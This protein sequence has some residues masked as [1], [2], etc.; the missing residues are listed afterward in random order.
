MLQ[1]FAIFENI[2]F[3]IL[4]SSFMVISWIVFFKL[5]NKSKGFEISFKSKCKEISLLSY[6]SEN[7]MYNI[8]LFERPILEIEYLKSSGILKSVVFIHS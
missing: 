7:V 2:I 8:P 6:L 1:T 3:S 4:G 5:F